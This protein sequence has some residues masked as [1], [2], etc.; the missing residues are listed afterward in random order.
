MKFSLWKSTVFIRPYASAQ[1]IIFLFREG[2]GE[3][4]S[5]AIFEPRSILVEQTTE[6]IVESNVSAFEQ[7][8]GERAVQH[9]IQQTGLDVPP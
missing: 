8:A 5:A 1:L 3:N 6:I 4:L 7:S 2:T 9:G